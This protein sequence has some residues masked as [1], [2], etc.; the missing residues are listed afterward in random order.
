MTQLPLGN[1]L[2]KFS[3]KKNKNNNNNNNKEK[4]KEKKKHDPYDRINIWRKST[5]TYLHPCN[6]GERITVYEF[7]NREQ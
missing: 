7:S 4:R 2:A 5:L 1:H 6:P 3:E